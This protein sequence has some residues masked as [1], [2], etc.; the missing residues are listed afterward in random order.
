MQSRDS[1]VKQLEGNL[2]LARHVTDC[3]SNQIKYLHMVSSWPIV[4]VPIRMKTNVSRLTSIAAIADATKRAPTFLFVSS[5]IA[6]TLI[7][8]SATGATRPCLRPDGL[9][10]RAG[11]H[12]LAKPAYSIIFDRVSL[13]IPCPASIFMKGQVGGA[14]IGDL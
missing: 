9:A 11:P 2:K 7:C 6:N 12:R 4:V 13:S 14:T 5:A 1:V 8:T 3:L 10:L